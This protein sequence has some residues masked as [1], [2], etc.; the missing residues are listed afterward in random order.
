M[1][2]QDDKMVTYVHVL[3]LTEASDIQ[4]SSSWSESTSCWMFI[5]PFLNLLERNDTDCKIGTMYV[6]GP[7]YADGV[8]SIDRYEL[9]VSC[10]MDVK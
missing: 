3:R 8:L 4:S 7:T 6:G 5:T 10:R 9:H 1:R 2:R